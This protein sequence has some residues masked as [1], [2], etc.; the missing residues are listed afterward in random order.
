MFLFYQYVFNYAFLRV[1]LLQYDSRSICLNHLSCVIW[2]GYLSHPFHLVR[3]Q[4][5]IVCRVFVCRVLCV[6]VC[7]CVCVLNDVTFGIVAWRNN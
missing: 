1:S 3:T 6:C 5:C 4:M 2:V 7:V